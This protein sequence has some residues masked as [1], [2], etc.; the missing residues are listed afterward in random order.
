[1]LVS[2]RAVMGL[3]PLSRM[4]FVDDGYRHDEYGTENEAFKR[5]QSGHDL[6]ILPCGFRKRESPLALRTEPVPC[7]LFI[8]HIGLMHRTS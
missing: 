7:E 4:P 1:M 8:L 2:G 6:P 3:F 5:E